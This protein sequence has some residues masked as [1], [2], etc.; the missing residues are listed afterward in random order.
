M[1]AAPLQP[2]SP[3]LVQRRPLPHDV[4]GRGQAQLHGP[5]L[6]SSQHLAR[7]ELIE[8]PAGQRM[9][10]RPARIRHPGPARVAEDLRPA[11]V[12]DGHPLPTPAA[13]DEP[14]QQGRP[15]S[16]SPLGLD[17]SPVLGKPPL[18]GVVPFLGD[19]RRDLVRD[20]GQV[21]VGRDQDPPRPPPPRL[22]AAR[23]ICRLPKQ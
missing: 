12:V 21:L 19:I 7:D 14:G 9:A 6:Q 2:L 18:V 23:S 13:D 15:L 5:G 10:T 20:Q 11:G 17:S 16:R 1:G 22:S 3:V 8:D 4:V